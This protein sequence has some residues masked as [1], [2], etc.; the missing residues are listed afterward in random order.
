MR[1]ENAEKPGLPPRM[2]AAWAILGMLVVLWGCAAPVRSLWPPGPDGTSKSIYVSLDTWHGMIAFPVEA[3]RSALPPGRRESG[4]TSGEGDILF[5]EWGFAER[6]WY[7]EGRQGLGGVLRALFWPSPGV[8]E[9][10]IHETPWAHRTPQPPSELFT[11][12]LT[13]E[14]YRRLRQHLHSTIE[15]TG[16]IS[17]ARPDTFYPA[18]RPYHL[19][20]TCHQYVAHALRTAGLP[21]SSL[22]AFSR[23]T[24]AWQLH[25]ASR[26]AEGEETETPA[27][28][29]ENSAG[30]R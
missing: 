12:R 10:G 30:Q 18:K 21:V 22:W 26:I 20:H 14:G 11:F 13:E 15:G 24:L 25:R 16:A 3:S 29:P 9:V 8:V 6:A 1:D 7:L 27:V 19:F 2:T 23:G 28:A 17:A 5:E 4:D